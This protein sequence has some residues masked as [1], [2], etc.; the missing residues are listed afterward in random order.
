MV[1]NGRALPELQDFST[2]NAVF[3]PYCTGDLHM[4]QQTQQG[5]SLPGLQFSGHN[6]LEGVLSTLADPGNS[7]GLAKVRVVVIVATATT[8]TTTATATATATAAATAAAAT[9]AIATATASCL[10]CCLLA[11]L[12][13]YLCRAT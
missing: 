5:Q 4:G 3:V 2:W 1:D 9:T 13:A 12:F 10:Y 6:V 8:T 7:F 11:A